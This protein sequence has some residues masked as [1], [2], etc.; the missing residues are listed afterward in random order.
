MFNDILVER[1]ADFVYV[2]RS[3]GLVERIANSK[4]GGMVIQKF[5]NSF[6]FVSCSSRLFAISVGPI[7]FCEFYG[8][9]IVDTLK[10]WTS[11]VKWFQ[12][13]SFGCD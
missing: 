8:K 3:S 2:L 4:I 5:R 12:G 13:I 11:K 6:S 7:L 1:D 9:V 10:K